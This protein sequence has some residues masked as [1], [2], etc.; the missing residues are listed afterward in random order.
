MGQAEPSVSYR[1]VSI[2]QKVLFRHFYS[3]CRNHH[4]VEVGYRM[5]PPADCPGD[6]HTIMTQCW[7][8]EAEERPN[9]A[10]ILEMLNNCLT[11]LR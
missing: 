1:E 10:Q 6:I 9:F 8:Y 2:I 5:G 7:Q 4:Q 11:Q 3:S